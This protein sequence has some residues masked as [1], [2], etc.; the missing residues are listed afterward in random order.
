MQVWGGGED[1]RKTLPHISKYTQIKCKYSENVLEGGTY[2][3]HH[4]VCLGEVESN[5]QLNP[6]YF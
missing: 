4:R 3:F 5:E 1:E 6:R 2:Q